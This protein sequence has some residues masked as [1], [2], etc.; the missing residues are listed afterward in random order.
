MAYGRSVNARG[1]SPVGV[2]R[3]GYSGGREGAKA[4]VS[5]VPKDLFLESGS[6]EFTNQLSSRKLT[7]VEIG[8]GWDSTRHLLF[9]PALRLLSVGSVFRKRPPCGSTCWSHE[10]G[11]ALASDSLQTPEYPPSRYEKPLQTRLGLPGDSRQLRL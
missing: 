3:A 7:L 6:A 9:P 4:L 2:A 1:E 8:G 11:R 10:L 5:R